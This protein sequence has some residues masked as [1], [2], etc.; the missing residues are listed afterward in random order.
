M[1]IR[2]HREA[3]KTNGKFDYPEFY[4][5]FQHAIA[6]V[7]RPE[8]VG[9]G[10]DVT[11]WQEATEEERE[12]IGG[13][14][15]GFTQLE[16]HVACYWGDVVCQLFPKHEIQAMA[17]AFSAS[18]AVHA[19]A[20]S[21]LSDT[22]GLDEFEAF[23][24]DP[25]ARAK[26]DLLCDERDPVTS[27]G[28][29][30]GAVEGVSLF[31]SFAALL[32]FNLDGRFKGISQIISWS[33]LDEQAHS[34]GGCALFRELRAEGAV[35]SKQEEDIVAGFE[36]VLENEDAFLEKIFNGHELACID[37]ADLWHYLRYRSNDRLRSLGLDHRFGYNALKADTVRKWFE[38]VLRG[39]V[40]NDFFAH[41]KEG[42]MY[43]SKP[44]QQFE[45]VKWSNLNLSL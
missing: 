15:R 24:G 19:A 10:S 40:S 27:L 21:H 44:S 25:T 17:R 28:V 37:C 34:D 39:Q 20:Y 45:R 7:W 13:I 14:L 23:L 12:V 22:L 29:F 32:A 36:A 41:T 35:S 9:M 11:D 42:S 8:E 3:Y 38:P 1:S 30:S 4:E 26:I 5:R 18:E 6:S 31:S 16:L 2:E 43:V 33:A